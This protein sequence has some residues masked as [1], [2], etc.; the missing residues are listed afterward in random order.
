MWKKIKTWFVETF[1]LNEDKRVTLEDLEVAQAVAQKDL[2]EANETINAAVVK[3][4]KSR[5]KK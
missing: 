3:V 4:K 1:D 5:K 2:K